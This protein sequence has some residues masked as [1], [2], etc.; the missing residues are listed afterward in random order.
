MSLAYC[1]ELMLNDHMMNEYFINDNWEDL[2]K[3]FRNHI[4]TPNELFFA[5]E[6]GAISC[7]ML[8]IHRRYYKSGNE[9]REALNHKQYQL[10]KFFIRKNYD[11][12]YDDIQKSADLGYYKICLRLIRNNSNYVNLLYK[13]AINTNNKVLFRKIYFIGNHDINIECQN[14]I[15]ASSFKWI[16]DSNINFDKEIDKF[17]E[18]AITTNNVNLFRKLYFEREFALS[19]HI[20]SLISKHNF[21][22]IEH[23]SVNLIIDTCYEQAILT[24]NVESFRNLYFK[25]NHPISEKIQKLIEDKDFNWLE[26]PVSNQ[27]IKYKKSNSTFWLLLLMGVFIFSLLLK[28]YL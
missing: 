13:Y 20:Q 25:F 26:I 8:V 1:T 9:I 19:D 7:I 14:L 2:L 23:S 6:N 28:Y 12:N 17:Y 11:Y 18:I 16:E 10:V 22:W 27:L 15:I 5:I 24:N 3:D 4:F 21:N